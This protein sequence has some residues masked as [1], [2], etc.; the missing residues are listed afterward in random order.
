LAF[1]AF[2]GVAA[3]GLLKGC[4]L[5]ERLSLRWERIDFER[6]DGHFI[7]IKS[8]ATSG[9]GRALPASSA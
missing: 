1:C 2:Q 7:D 8:P 6:G 9:G 5:S 3:I 4:R